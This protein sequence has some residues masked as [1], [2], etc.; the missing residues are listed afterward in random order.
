MKKVIDTLDGHEA[1]VPVVQAL[2]F[3]FMLSTMMT[4]GIVALSYL[5][6]SNIT[7]GIA[8]VVILAQFIFNAVLYVKVSNKKGADALEISE[9]VDMK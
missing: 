7:K 6:N 5:N 4:F 9:E 1:V 3:G 2:L 8:V